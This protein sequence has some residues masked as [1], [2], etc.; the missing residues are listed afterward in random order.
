MSE[1]DNG[2]TVI[3]SVDYVYFDVGGTP[4]DVSYITI[5]LCKNDVPTIQVGIA[6]KKASK[7]T[8][9]HI[10]DVK[11]LKDAYAELLEKSIHLEDSN[12]N[13][14]IVSENHPEFTQELH[15]ENWPLVSVGMTHVSATDL[16]ELECVIAHPAY[17]TRLFEGFFFDSAIPINKDALED[18]ENPLDAAD[19]VFE[20][21]KEVD[22]DVTHDFMV[23]DIETSMEQKNQNSLD[24]ILEEKMDMALYYKNSTLVWDLPFSTAE[25]NIPCE[26]YLDGEMLNGM[27]HALCNAWLQGGCNTTVWGRLTGTV[28]PWFMCEVIP[29]Y[30]SESPGG[31]ET[32]KLKVT[33]I[34]PWRMRSVHLNDLRVH[35]FD[36]PGYDPNPL[37]GVSM[38]Q[39]SGTAPQDGG[40]SFEVIQ[41]EKLGI[42]PVR[43]SYIP[44]DERESVGKLLNIQEPDW[45]KLILSFAAPREGQPDMSS[46][47]DM[48]AD[49]VDDEKTDPDPGGENENEQVKELNTALTAWACK[50]FVKEYRNQVV[51][52]CSCA[53][54]IYTEYGEL[55][56]PGKRMQYLT[57]DG[58]VLFSGEIER[59]EHSIDCGRSRATTTIM[60][61]YC[62]TDGKT[63]EVLGGNGDKAMFGLGEP[64]L[65]FP[66]YK[67]TGWVDSGGGP[68]MNP[69]DDF[70]ET[71]Y[72]APGADNSGFVF[73]SVNNPYLSL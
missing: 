25:W 33:P 59:V 41:K 45:A 52:T 55:V 12:L 39:V 9:V 62:D 34:N 71:A 20:A 60:V 3:Y 19:I 42:Q 46:F 32:T 14:R 1:Y 2:R 69:Y 67:T 27:K 48:D 29:N 40:V 51:A 53:L 4:Y 63:A 57:G 30:A 70:A 21:V 47:Q 22:K 38:D 64:Q 56:Y 24:E 37:F 18:A 23:E 17:K 11:T 26:G 36:M 73:E 28:C 58:T 5:S 49:Y 10:L 31:V 54:T 16:F 68:Y 7:K 8:E 13:F 15:I 43:L 6:P 61:A 66:V 44:K 72:D 65:L 50:T 35:S